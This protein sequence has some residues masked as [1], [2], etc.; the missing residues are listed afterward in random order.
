MQWRKDVGFWSC[1][2]L[3]HVEAEKDAGAK[4]NMADSD[5]K[6]DQSRKRR[7]TRSRTKSSQTDEADELQQECCYSCHSVANTLAEIN[8][9][10]DVALERIKEIEELKE[11]ISKLEKENE[12]LKESIN[13][14]C[15]QFVNLKCEA[16]ANFP[17]TAKRMSKLEE[18]VKFLCKKLSE[19]PE[20]WSIKLE[21][22]SRRNNLKF[23]K[24]EEQQNETI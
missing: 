4:N 7:R 23:F 22:H 20:E 14:N 12:S 1:S 3:K 11:R 10:L 17:A 2:D 9:K 5:Q 18:G 6:E 21:G 13:Y 19:E 15:I 16:Q 8:N 24:I